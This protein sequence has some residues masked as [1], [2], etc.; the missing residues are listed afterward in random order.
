ML[1]KSSI[2]PYTRGIQYFFIVV[3][4]IG[5]FFRFFN[6][7]RKIYWYDE[8]F[9]SIRI[10]GYTETEIAKQAFNNR[11]I[12]SQ[13]LNKFQQP[14]LGDKGVIGTIQGLEKEEPQ[15]TPFYFI[16][17]RFWT[18]QFGGSIAVTRS[19]SAVL[20]LLVFPSVYWLCQ[21]LFETS[22]PV[23]WMS[24][25][26]VAI[27]PIQVLYAQEARMYSL[28]TGLVLLSSAALLKA[29]RTQTSLN[30]GIYALTLSLSLYTHLFTVL[31]IIGH[32]LYVLM[33][34]QFRINI[35]MPKTLFNLRFYF[36]KDLVRYFTA[37][38]AALVSFSP[39]L[40]IIFKGAAQQQTTTSW[41]NNSLGLFALIKS[42]ST[43]FSRIF[44]DFGLNRDSNSLLLLA[45]IPIFLGCIFLVAISIYNLCTKTPK[46]VYLFILIMS[47]TPIFILGLRDVISGG[48]LSTEARYLL[49]SYIFAQIAISHLI[50]NQFTGSKFWKLVT[51]TLVALGISSCIAIS[52]ATSWWNK[53]E[54]QN[55]YNLQVATII[56]QSSSPLLIAS[57]NISNGYSFIDVILCLNHMLDPKVKL[58]LTVEPEF[59]NITSTETANKLFV[60]LPSVALR[61]HLEKDFKVESAMP[62]EDPWL[63][64]LERRNPDS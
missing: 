7:D 39:W 6:L 41:A 30:W 44:I 48:Q 33:T 9:T 55:K 21:E 29:I 47:F 11:V 19:L 25:T 56:N 1:N 27:S 2:H 54:G 13:F 59:P 10:S 50:C 34:Q 57:G 26:M 40:L 24:L 37:L 5:I 16:L 12:D 15:L 35:A 28:W 22:T 63:W 58:K 8:V 53:G 46:K 14:T 43:D 32:S 18:E 49:P 42:W 64:K 31:T 23:A 36:P 3:L 60:Y 38:I 52:Q 51:I 4:V 45:M 20:S 62:V 17:A 61:Q